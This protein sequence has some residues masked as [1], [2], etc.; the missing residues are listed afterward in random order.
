M[1]REAAIVNGIMRMLRDQPV[2]WCFKMHG[3]PYATAGVPDII[4]VHAG[5]FFGIEVKQP[6]KKP[7]KL[8]EHT[9]KLIER[10]GGMCCVATTV[11]EARQFLGDVSTRAGLL[12]E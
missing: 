11:E 12:P 4:G 10:A 3:G 1:P 2:T 7:T 6:G 5:F 8:Q 9:M